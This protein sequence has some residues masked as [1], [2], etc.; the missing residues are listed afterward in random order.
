[1][2]IARPDRVVRTLTALASCAYFGMWVGAALVLVGF[3][4]VKGFGGTEGGFY[5]SLE[6][7]VTAPTS[8]SMV[9][10]VWGPAP[11]L[12]GNVRGE[13]KLPISTMPWSFVVLLWSYTAIAAALL[14]LFLHNLRRVFQRV[15]DGAAFDA[16]NVARLRTLGTVLIAIACVN[17]VAEWATSIVV[18]RGLAAGSSVAVPSGFHVDGTLV[19][20]ALVL[21]ALAEVFRRG[22][23]LEDDQSLVV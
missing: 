20:V 22:A 15:R 11:L 10:T 23:Q 7:P 18:R 14:L 21:I 17:A 16:R 2:G 8:Q 6:L 9:Q 1:M 13:L 3:P 4:V 12:L 5:Y 19:L